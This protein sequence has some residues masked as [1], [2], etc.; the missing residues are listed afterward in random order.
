VTGEQTTLDDS[1]TAYLARCRQATD[2]PLAVGFGISRREDVAML[3]G[4]ADMAVIGTATIQ[5]VDS[6]GADA[7][8]P[9]IAG[10]LD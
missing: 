4:K 6:Q 5:L 9:F 1:L 2:L 3:R 10:L 8:G 7:V